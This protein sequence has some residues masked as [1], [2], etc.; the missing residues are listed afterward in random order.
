MYYTIVFM[1]TQCTLV[2][3]ATIPQ[4]THADGAVLVIHHLFCYTV[5]PP[6]VI[7][8]NA[9]VA[10]LNGLWLL[11]PIN[12]KLLLSQVESLTAS[13]I[14]C[15]I[16]PLKKALADAGV[17]A[18]DISEVILINGITCMLR[19]VETVKT[20]FSHE[21]S[22]GVNPDEAVAIGAS[23]QGGV[24]TGNITDI[25]LFDVTSLSLGILSPFSGITKLTHFAGIE[26]LGSIM[27]KLIL[28]N[29]TILTKSLYKITSFLETSIWLAFYLHLS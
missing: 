15:I 28:H 16:E 27:T 21:P 25:L 19:V 7:L 4:C 12:Q 26:T 20:V 5:H 6:I 13:L 29:T 24:L 1:P 18:S 10:E 8:V 22:K 3:P 23:I 17:K 11:V 9:I 2:G 14:Q